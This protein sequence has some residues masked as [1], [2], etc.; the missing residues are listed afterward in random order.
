M[1]R[2][3]AQ[4]IDLWRGLTRTVEQIRR[5]VDAILVA[6]Q[7]LPLAWFEVLN[8]LARAKG[9]TMRVSDLVDTLGEVPSSLSR[10]LDRIEEEG[11]VERLVTPPGGDRRAVM[12]ALV[13][14]GRQQW[15]AAL[16]DFRRAVQHQ[17][18]EVLTDSDITALTRVL[19]KLP[20]VD[21]SDDDDG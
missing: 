14:L 15:R 5:R 19:A 3:D 21:V 13:P 10:R 2:L 1:P 20:V 7:Q 12:V 8:A 4:R 16:P 17:F 11:Y 9:A 6:E 18:A